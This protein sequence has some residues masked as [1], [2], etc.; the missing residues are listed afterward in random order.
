MVKCICDMAEQR[1]T[2]KSREESQSRGLHGSTQFWGPE[3]W[4]RTWVMSSLKN[5]AQSNQAGLDLLLLSQVSVCQY[6]RDS[7]GSERTQACA[8]STADEVVCYHHHARKWE[9][10]EVRN[11]QKGNGG[12]FADVQ[13]QVKGKL[14]HEGKSNWHISVSVLLIIFGPIWVRSGIARVLAGSVLSFLKMYLF[15]SGSGWLSMGLFRTDLKFWTP[16][17]LYHKVNKLTL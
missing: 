9:E 4:T 5:I 8:L 1:S 6:I 17:D 14:V 2:S 13:E 10:R 12:V 15:M 7:N 11:M 3:T 16:E